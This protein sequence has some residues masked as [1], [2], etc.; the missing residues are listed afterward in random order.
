M[1]RNAAM[2]ILCLFFINGCTV[3]SYN[4]SFPK[5]S[6]YWSNDAENQRAEQ[7]EYKE[8]ND[9]YNRTNKVINR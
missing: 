8:F 9:N 6:W 4:R 2:L 1:R 5:L 7:K 3:V